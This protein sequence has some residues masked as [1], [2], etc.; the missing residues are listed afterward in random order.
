LMVYYQRL[1]LERAKWAL[2][3]YEKF[4]EK[5]SLKRIRDILDSE[6]GDSVVESLLLKCPADFTD[7]LNFFEFVG[8]LKMNGHLKLS[9]FEGLFDYYLR[10]LN[11]HPRVKNFILEN[12]YEDLDKLLADWK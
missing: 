12:G 1:K 4:Y 2:S 3:L 6:L 7:Y 8:F 11:R 9:E 5:D 10:C